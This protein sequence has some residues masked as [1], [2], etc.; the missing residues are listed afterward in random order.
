MWC[1]V[2]PSP[3]FV[4]Q[5]LFRPRD[6]HLTI[7]SIEDASVELQVRSLKLAARISVAQNLFLKTQIKKP[8]NSLSLNNK[9]HCFKRHAFTLKLP[10]HRSLRVPRLEMSTTSTR[11]QFCSFS[12]TGTI[13]RGLGVNSSQSSCNLRRRGLEHHTL[14][15]FTTVMRTG[16]LQCRIQNVETSL[17]A[18]AIRVDKMTAMLETS[19]FGNSAKLDAIDER[20]SLI[21][22][23]LPSNFLSEW[24]SFR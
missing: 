20:I 7:A 3:Y 13:G 2:V 4:I 19:E 14:D 16:A 17:Q 9:Q 10:Y 12:T 11:S 23:T 21:E 6:H 15:F 18:N 8:L 24:E 1:H 5:G 22:T